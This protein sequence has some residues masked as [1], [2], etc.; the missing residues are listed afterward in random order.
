VLERPWSP[1]AGRLLVRVLEDKTHRRLV[2]LA[3][4]ELHAWLLDHEDVVTRL[5]LE[6][7]PAWTPVWL[8]ERVA[9]RAYR[10][11]L[12]WVS[13]VREDPEHR[14]RIAVDDAL[15]RLAKDLQDD[16]ETIA[17]AEELKERLLANPGVRDALASLWTT[18]RTVLVEATQ[19]P[20]SDL[21]LRTVAGLAAFGR[22]LA[23]DVGLQASVDRYL[24]DAVGH[25]VSTYRDEVGGIISETVQRWDG[26]EASRRIELHVGRDLQFIR[27]NGTVV[28]GL[29][30][31]AIHTVAVLVP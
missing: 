14:V 13:D 19:D 6:R 29:V 23:A 3:V 25:V 5:V 28:G 30:G 27:I 31:L 22:R 15:G 9:R 12:Q 20:A 11:A 8:D 2:D 16:P 26:Q 1:P 10:E 4:V 21:R 18:A 7:A 24:T 17:R